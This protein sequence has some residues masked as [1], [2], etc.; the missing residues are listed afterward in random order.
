M[1]L[2][3]LVLKLVEYRFFF[4]QFSLEVYVGLIAI[5]FT[6]FGIWIGLRLVKSQ[7]SQMKSV[8]KTFNQFGISKRE[9]EVLHLMA[10]GLS[11]QQIADQLFISLPTVK[12]HSSNL[13]IKLNVQRRTQAILKA[14]EIGL[15]D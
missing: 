12:T 2:L 3:V 14:K 8:T 10:K 7:D 6:G 9:Y 1:A 13:F 5:L 4:R 11:N 15:V